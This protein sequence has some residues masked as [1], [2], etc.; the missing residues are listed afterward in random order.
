MVVRC[1]VLIERDEEL[2]ALTGL[3]CEAIDQGARAVVLTGESG[4]GK[5]RLAQEFSGSLPELWSARMLRLTRPG[6]ALPALTAERPLAV[7]LDDAH[8]LD[9]SALDALS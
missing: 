8:F 9:P 6:A 3:A 2:R 7:V 4:A 5:S 1:P